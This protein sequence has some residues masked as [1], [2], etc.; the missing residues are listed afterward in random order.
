MVVF[1]P[2]LMVVFFPYPFPEKNNY[3]FP[4]VELTPKNGYSGL[5]H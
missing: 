4:L 3:D 5:Y 1:P 2:A